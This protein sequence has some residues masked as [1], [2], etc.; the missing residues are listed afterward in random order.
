[1]CD[2]LVMNVNCKRRKRMRSDDG[3]GGDGP[4]VMQRKMFIN[5]LQVDRQNEQKMRQIEEKTMNML[6][7]G[8]K[9]SSQQRPGVCQREC[10]KH[11]RLLGTGEYD[12]DIANC[13]AWMA[14]KADRECR[15]CD[16]ISLVHADCT[17]CNLE[18][19]EFCGISCHYC[20]EK[21]CMNCVNIFNCRNSDVPCCERCKIFN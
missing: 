1:M 5:Q 21:I 20:P 4:F 12:F 7:L 9:T 10:L 17:N 6:F 18:L 15:I 14:K 8:A 16:R 11:V 3:D 2:I 13:P 19:C